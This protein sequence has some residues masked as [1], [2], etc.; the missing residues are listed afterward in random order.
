MI[1]LCIN[2]SCYTVYHLKHDHVTT[3]PW[4]ENASLLIIA[5]DKA[6]DGVDQRFLDYFLRGG[7]LVS[8]G[9]MFDSLIVRRKDRKCDVKGVGVLRLRYNSIGNEQFAAICTRYCYDITETVLPGVVVTSIA[10]DHDSGEDV[11][12]EAAMKESSGV[13]ILLQVS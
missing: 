1:C 4:N 13:A 10:T 11:I 8:F 5:S 2:T 7:T 9:S 3:T 6:Y 12:V